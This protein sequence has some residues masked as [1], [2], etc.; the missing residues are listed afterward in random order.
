MTQPGAGSCSSTKGDA[1]REMLQG[2]AVRRNALHQEERRAERRIRKEVCRV[3]AIMT[4]S[5]VSFCV[6]L[7]SGPKSSRGT[8]P[9]NGKEKGGVPA[10]S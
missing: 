8:M 5:Y 3:M 2:Y 10:M 4:A 9:E 6:L 1:Q 7:M